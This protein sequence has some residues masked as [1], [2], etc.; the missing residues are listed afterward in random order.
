MKRLAIALLLAVAGAVMVASAQDRGRRLTQRQP[1]NYDSTNI[2]YDGRL[3]FVRVR[4]A[5]GFSGFGRFI[6]DR[7]S[8]KLTLTQYSLFRWGTDR[9]PLSAIDAVGISSDT[10]SLRFSIAISHPCS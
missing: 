10:R 4:Y 6:F 3:S 8:G 7:Q 2:G 5:A 1:Q 9:Y